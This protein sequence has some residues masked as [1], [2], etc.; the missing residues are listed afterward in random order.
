[1][2]N[3]EKNIRRALSWGK[4]IVKEQIVVDTGSTDR[5]VEIAKEMGAKVF[6]FTWID[7]FS[8]AKNYAIDQAK[9]NWI[10]FLDADEYLSKEDARKMFLLLEKIEE[11][12][13]KQKKP[14]ILRTALADLN[15]AGKV[16]AVTQQ[17]RF[18]QNVPNLRYY[19][20]VHE[21]IRVPFGQELNI[22]DVSE[23][24]TIFHT[25]YTEKV[26]LETNKLE[27]N[28]A[29]LRK[30]IEKNPE[31]YGSIEYLGESLEIAGRKEEAEAAYRKV[32]ACGFD[33]ISSKAKISILRSLMGMQVDR[34]DSINE[35]GS[36]MQ[37]LYEKALQ[38][39]EKHPDCDF[40]MG[41]WYFKKG[42]FE[43]CIT[44]IESALNKYDLNQSKLLSYM[45]HKLEIS[46]TMLVRCYLELQNPAKAVQSA[47]LSLRLNRYNEIMLNTLLDVLKNE[48]TDETYNFLKKLYNMNDLKDKLLVIK[49]A[50]IISF[51]SLAEKVLSTLSAEEQQWLNE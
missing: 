5:T 35:N 44:Y 45:P 42:G 37:E 32:L 28:I 21:Q 23:D 49:S 36:C 48:S 51:P 3:E 12:K 38:V 50:K 39:D 1:M 7:D 47:V 41:A 19:N 9:G 25:G 27:R 8:A 4:D 22:A 15:M 13:L 43:E 6:H 18:F 14:H 11:G 24:I 40:L 16:S 30:E 46:Y 33:Q 17:D 31:D 2:K 10:A 20:R 34:T 26:Y 29:L